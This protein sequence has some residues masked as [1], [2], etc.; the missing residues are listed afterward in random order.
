MIKESPSDNNDL[1]IFGSFGFGNI[2]DEAV[3]YAM[4][5]LLEDIN[6][7]A[8]THILSRFNTPTMPD[9]I[10]LGS[11]YAPELS[12]LKGAPGLLVGG[13]I[14]EPRNMCCALRYADYIKRNQPLGSS[15]FM[16]SFEFG[17]K[18]GWSVKR[19]F[20]QLFERL[21]HIYTRDYLSEMYLRENFPQVN[22]STVADVVLAMRPT[23][24]RPLQNELQNDEYIAVSLCGAWKVDRQWY[25]WIIKELMCLSESL[26][27]LLVF[28]PMSCHASDDDRV[29]HQKIVDGMIQAGVSRQPLLLNQSL[30]PKIFA[31]LLRDAALVISM[32]L[33]GCVIA[34][35]QQTPFVGLSYH[36]KLN[37][38]SQTVGWR[39]FVL[40]AKQPA[41][42]SSGQYGYKFSDL[43]FENNDLFNTA[44]NAMEHGSFN[45]LPLLR[46]RLGAAL[47]H[48]LEGWISRKN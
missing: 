17:V 19:R 32:R 46:G 1:V 15:I 45:L 36:P 31:A 20:N 25:R 6:Y 30:P 38:F 47:G 22:T 13:G 24:D 9:V 33:H 3:S 2:G 11:D 12:G 4:Q 34:Y 7:Q 21:D 29:E 27:K 40:P 10:G 28:V 16:G 5:D 37:G 43:G 23:T 18:Y 42:Q 35:A 14:I 44:Y 39:N 48:I 41:K 26:G 8:Q